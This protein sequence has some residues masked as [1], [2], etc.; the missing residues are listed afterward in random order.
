MYEVA[1]L[2]Y[3]LEKYND[4]M[5]WAKQAVDNSNDF[6]HWYSGQLAQFYNK[7]GK[8]QESAEVFAYMVE[9]EP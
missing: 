8:Y 6:N 9:K 4:A 1:K 7:F 3:Q 5:Y 2:Y